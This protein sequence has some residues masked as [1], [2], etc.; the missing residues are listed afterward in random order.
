MEKLSASGI[1]GLFEN[2]PNKPRKKTKPGEFL[3]NTVFPRGHVREH[4][5]IHYLNERESADD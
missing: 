1:A 4:D 5:A 2:F 3:L